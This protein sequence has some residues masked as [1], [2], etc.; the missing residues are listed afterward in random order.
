[1]SVGA[2]LGTIYAARSLGDDGIG[3]GD[4]AQIAVM[5]ILATWVLSQARGVL[6]LMRVGRSSLDAAARWRDRVLRRK[7]PE[8][9]APWTA[10]PGMFLLDSAPLLAAED[11]RSARAARA[12][13]ARRLARQ[14][15]Q[16]A[17]LWLSLLVAT[18]AYVTFVLVIAY[19][20]VEG[21]PLDPDVLIAFPFVLL[22][23]YSLWQFFRAARRSAF[24]GRPWYLGGRA[25]R[26][27]VRTWG[28]GSAA[29]Q[30]LVTGTAALSVASAGFVPSWATSREH[31]DLFAYDN[32]NGVLYRIDLATGEARQ[33]GIQVFGLRLVS[34]ATLPVPVTA[35]DGSRA[36]PHSMVALAE[37]IR[38]GREVLTVLPAGGGRPFRLALL[39]RP[40]GEAA[41]AAD[42]A[43]NLLALDHDGTLWRVAKDGAVTRLADTGVGA[44]ALEFTPGT[45]E[46][47]AVAGGQ[48][49]RIN[50][51][52]GRVLGA[53]P[54]P[55]LAGLDVCEMALIDRDR[56]LVADRST[57]SLTVIDAQSG[58]LVGTVL[59]TNAVTLGEPCGLTVA[60][61]LD[62]VPPASPT[63]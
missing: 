29:L 37:D 14:R 26:D 4:A 47:V 43:G 59:I 52:T 31:T 20:S 57:G 50:P 16:P 12:L 27:S 24:R 22:G 28:S 1:M 62:P 2:L 15:W 46:L 44:S 55:G 25:F 3:W 42:A 60:T 11:T 23:A 49:V 41:L 17:L 40:L 9:P 53:T 38:T 51:I 13:R 58:E 56:M 19:V 33:F 39:D 54:A 35:P 63:P 6:R 5:A 48:L 21:D 61:R 7:P 10:P 34:L 36:G 30:L 32:A 18:L 8:V 45:R